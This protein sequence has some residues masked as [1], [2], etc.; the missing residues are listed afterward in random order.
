MP[1]ALSKIRSLFIAL[2]FVLLA[3]TA[4]VAAQEKV[5]ISVLLDP[6]TLGLEYMDWLENEWIPQFERDNPD[7]KVS[8]TRLSGNRLDTV[9]VAVAAGLPW[10]IV[11]AA[12]THPL[13]EGVR[14]RWYPPQNAYIEQ[15]A[16]DEN[17]I[18]TVREPTTWNE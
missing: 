5:E 14:L 7:I 3:G 2:C 9:A 16:D 4:L 11:P 15:S 18:T 6:T 17:M 10:D 12:H 13:F 1:R 8:T